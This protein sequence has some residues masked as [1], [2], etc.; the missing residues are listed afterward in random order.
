MN[1][2]DESCIIKINCL[3]SKVYKLEE[4]KSFIQYMLV[5]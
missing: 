3:I 5:S 4:R 2:I 1:V